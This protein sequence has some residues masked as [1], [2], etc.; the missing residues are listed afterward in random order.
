M[1]R[2]EDMRFQA[3]CYVNVKEVQ[4]QIH[5]IACQAQIRRR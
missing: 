4:L 5:Q 3:P 1:G 2:K